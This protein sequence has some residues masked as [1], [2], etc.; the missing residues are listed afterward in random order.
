MLP[1]CRTIGSL[2]GKARQG[3]KGDQVDA[4]Q[5]S[6]LLRRGGLRAVY[7]GSAHG[8]TLKEF[9]R[10]LTAVTLRLWQTGERY[11]P[12]KLTMQAR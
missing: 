5:L 10:K 7:H 9:T 2:F 4:D 11:D 12:A 6:E 3:N 8:A 1:F